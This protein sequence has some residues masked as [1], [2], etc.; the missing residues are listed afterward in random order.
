[1]K[2]KIIFVLT[3]IFVVLLFLTSACAAKNDQI[4]S[5]SNEPEQEVMDAVIEEF[6]NK[7]DENLTKDNLVKI[8]ALE[9][10]IC[11]F[12][13]TAENMAKAKRLKDILSGDYSWIVIFTR[14][15]DLPENSL[16]TSAAICSVGKGMTVSEYEAACKHYG[17]EIDETFKASLAEEEG[18]W[19]THALR[20]TTEYE[21][22][23]LDKEEAYKLFKEKGVTP[24]KNGDEIVVASSVLLSGMKFICTQ[25]EDGK[26]YVITDAPI[27]YG[28]YFKEGELYELTDFFQ[29]QKAFY[30]YEK[31]VTPIDGKNENGEEVYG[32]VY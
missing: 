9:Y 2:R 8:Y 20:S 26:E 15:N 16:I 14:K 3:S 25:A 10:D 23:M 19:V 5:F 31:S 27:W 7:V 24:V 1:M 30:E 13:K 17:A 11:D 18:K 12:D 22:K 32:G 21:L 28:E 6:P 29:R 4:K